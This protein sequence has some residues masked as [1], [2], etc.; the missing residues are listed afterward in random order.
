MSLN[1]KN[2]RF[3]VRSRCKK[4]AGSFNVVVISLACIQESYDSEPK[5][6]EGS[7]SISR[8]PVAHP[9]DGRSIVLP[10]CDHDH[11]YVKFLPTVQ[12]VRAIGK[13]PAGMLCLFSHL[14]NV[15]VLPSVGTSKLPVSVV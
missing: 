13:P 12:R 7:V 5:W 1:C 10:F 3:T 2:R 6:L 9:G 8:S 14:K 11:R 15:V 4:L